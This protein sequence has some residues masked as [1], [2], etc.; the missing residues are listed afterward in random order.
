MSDPKVTI[1]LTVSNVYVN[2]PQ[3]IQSDSS[4][5]TKVKNTQSYLAEKARLQLNWDGTVSAV[6]S[7]CPSEES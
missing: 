7:C 2:N 6:K 5:T 4:I 1:A 3:D